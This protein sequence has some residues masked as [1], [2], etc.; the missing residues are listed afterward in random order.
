MTKMP[1]RRGCGPALA[2][3]AALSMIGS[4]ASAV[5]DP[6]PKLATDA[7]YEAVR[8]HIKAKAFAAALPV[9]AK[10]REDYPSEPDVF[11]LTGFS[12]RKSGRFDEAL[13]LY[14]QAL[15]LDPRHL[16]ANEYLGELYAE[17]GKLDLAR[18]RL[19]VLEAACGTGC[20]QTQDLAKA[21]AAAEKK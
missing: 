11:S 1:F 9:L 5:D 2:L 19:A 16:G 6:S 4:P 7:R 8:A 17:T 12:L 14:G 3:A 20:E 15:M 18:E 21:I 13:K 10:L